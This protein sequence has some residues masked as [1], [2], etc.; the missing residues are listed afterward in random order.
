MA[1]EHSVQIKA[2]ANRIGI[3]VEH[4]CKE[5]KAKFRDSLRPDFKDL[6]RLGDSKEEEIAKI[7]LERLFKKLEKL[8]VAFS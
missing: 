8:D 4:A 5:L 7:M 3:E 1:N 2:T 6:S